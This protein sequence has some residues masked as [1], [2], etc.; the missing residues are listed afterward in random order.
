MSQVESI[1]RLSNYTPCALVIL[2]NHRR[3][4]SYLLCSDWFI[5]WLKKDWEFIMIMKD[6]VFIMYMK[7]WVFIKSMMENSHVLT[8]SPW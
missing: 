2:T 3:A 6:W 5:R 4:L 8:P 7:D 1:L